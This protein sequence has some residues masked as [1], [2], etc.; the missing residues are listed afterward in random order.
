MKRINLHIADEQDEKLE[1]LSNKTGVPKAALIRRSIDAFL[2][3]AE[4]QSWDQFKPTYSA[5]ITKRK[6]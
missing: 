3:Y 6:R 5:R 1:E 4:K 2:G